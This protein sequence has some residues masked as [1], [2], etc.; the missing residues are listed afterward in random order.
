MV[1]GT[2]IIGA[3]PLDKPDPTLEM[4]PPGLVIGALV[5]KVVSE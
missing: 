1:T 2:D 4:T 5:V 3:A